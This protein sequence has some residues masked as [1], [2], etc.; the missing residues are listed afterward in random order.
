MYNKIKYI[1]FRC[2]INMWSSNLYKKVEEILNNL[3]LK[4][5]TNKTFC[6]RFYND[7]LNLSFSL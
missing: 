1:L 4:I 6:I 7:N 3:D 2:V 5:N